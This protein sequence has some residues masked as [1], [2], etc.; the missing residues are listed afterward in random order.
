M[1]QP[2]DSPASFCNLCHQ[3]FLYGFRNLRNLKKWGH[4]YFANIPPPK[5]N[6]DKTL[7][8]VFKYS[9]KLVIIS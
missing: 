1:C 8:L 4:N 6:L 9:S 5:K 3:R 7:F 2:F